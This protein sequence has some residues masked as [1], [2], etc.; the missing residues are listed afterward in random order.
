MVLE[1]LS[2]REARGR[3]ANITGANRF[4]I[5]NEEGIDKSFP[6]I[7]R[8]RQEPVIMNNTNE[9][10]KHIH[11]NASYAKV[12]KVNWNRKR[13]EENSRENMREWKRVTDGF[14]EKSSF[15]RDL[16]NPYKTTEFEK[17]I[18][19]LNTLITSWMT[20][21]TTEGNTQT[22]LNLVKNIKEIIEDAANE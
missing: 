4:E 6:A 10:A 18:K 5:F 8:K 19:K 11:K 16:E 3:Y 14:G 1:N 17:L 7:K 21:E 12:A 9:A 20:N 13:E 2:F 15:T 22:N